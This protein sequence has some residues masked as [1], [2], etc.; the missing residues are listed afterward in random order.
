MYLVEKIFKN[1]NNN[2]IYVLCSKNE[3]VVELFLNISFLTK[4]LKS[5]N[6]MMYISNFTLFSTN[7]SVKKNVK[8]F[9]LIK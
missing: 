5:F 1:K 6:I 2:S 8:S 4:K 3:N 9:I 7:I